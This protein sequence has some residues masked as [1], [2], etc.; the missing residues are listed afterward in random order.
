MKLSTGARWEESKRR[1]KK[2]KNTHIT[3][4]SSEGKRLNAG[5]PKCR[6]TSALIGCFNWLECIISWQQLLCLSPLVLGGILHFKWI[7]L[8]KWLAD[9]P[10]IQEEREDNPL[11]LS[12]SSLF[13]PLFTLS[14]ASRGRIRGF[15]E[16][17]LRVMSQ[18][19]ARAQ[20]GYTRMH[21]HPLKRMND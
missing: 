12:L 19:H 21:A 8:C 15:S 4:W 20:R 13:L 17:L 2:K 7:M 1:R 14:C 16:G 18:T 10:R 6:D 5:T 3:H 11:R 9:L